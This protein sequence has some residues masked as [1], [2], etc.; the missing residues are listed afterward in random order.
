MLT[1]KA[2]HSFDPVLHFKNIPKPEH[3]Q[4]FAPARERQNIYEMI[5]AVLR[6][7]FKLPYAQSNVGLGNEQGIWLL[8]HTNMT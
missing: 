8:F 5:Y 7:P 6:M 4:A 2:E 1:S 3:R